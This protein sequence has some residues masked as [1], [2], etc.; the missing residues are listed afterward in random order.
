MNGCEIWS[1]GDDIGRLSG[2][3]KAI[4]SG[5]AAGLQTRLGTSAVPGMVR[6][7]LLSASFFGRVRIALL[8]NRAAIFFFHITG[9]STR[10]VR[11]SATHLCNSPTACRSVSSCTEEVMRVVNHDRANSKRDALLSSVA[12]FRPYLR[13][14]ID[15]GST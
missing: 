14:H 6:L 1:K 2:H 4:A 11:L 13:P 10:A 15:R 8:L 9:M 3:R 5:G 12:G 7:H